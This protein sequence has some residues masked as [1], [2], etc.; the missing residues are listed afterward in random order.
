[1]P[2]LTFLP[3]ILEEHLA[4]IGFLWGQRHEALS[5]P[6][7]T[8]HDFAELDGR[9]LAHLSGVLTT[10]PRAPDL[11][12]AGLD[13][14]DGLE[15]FASAF[16][17]LHMADPEG[18]ARLLGQFSAAEDERLDG[19]RDALA[20][21][22]AGD[23]MAHVQ[24]L[25][26]SA[27]ARVAVA[28]ATVLA[29][30]GPIAL[31]DGWMNRCLAHDDAPVRAAAWNLLSIVSAPLSPEQT[32]A[33]LSDDDA[34][35]VNAALNAAIWRG[36]AVALEVARTTAE[37]PQ[38]DNFALLRMLAVL[39]APSEIGVFERILDTEEVGPNRFELAGT[40]GHPGL[41]GRLIEAMTGADA[42]AAAAAGRAFHKLTGV[43]V[44]SNERVEVAPESADPE[45]AEF[46]AEFAMEVMLPD[47]AAAATA[48]QRLEPAFAHV[49]RLCHGL[50]LTQPLDQT[51]FDDLDMESRREIFMRGRFYGSW[52]GSPAQLSVFP[53]SA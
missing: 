6:D 49:S 7:Y 27:Q 50:D 18:I 5:S 47:A 34:V 51:R 32:V 15:T 21:G 16:S 24:E 40:F 44:E 37:N 46:D 36:E 42:E 9:I 19:L 23:H 29:R 20:Y 43:D 25:S 14:D 10:G 28:A 31:P 3:D 52:T 12:A 17:L 30:R 26:G 39:A 4:E 35:V 33:A 1:M 8:F 2:R 11:V 22:P 41:V 45:D 53:Q 38:P 48:W 13:S